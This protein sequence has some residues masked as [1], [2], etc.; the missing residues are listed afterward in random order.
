MLALAAASS[1][2]WAPAANL[3]PMHSLPAISRAARP[4][5]LDVSHAAQWIADAAA[6]LDPIMLPDTS[7]AAATAVEAVAEAEPGWFD[8]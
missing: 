4:A 7:A 6:G 3:A 8:L 5:M 2:A 1:Q